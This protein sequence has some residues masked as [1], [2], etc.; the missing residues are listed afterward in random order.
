[1]SE[2]LTSDARTLEARPEGPTRL[3]RW[4]PAVIAVALLA[5]AVV[6]FREAGS[7]R[8]PWLTNFV[9]VFVSLLVQAFPFVLLGALVSAGIEVFVPAIALRR[10]DRL[11]RFLQLPVAALSGLA[12]P[13]C[14]CGS[15]PVARRL[16]AK[17]LRPSAA[18]AFML[19]SPVINPIVIVSTAVA[20][21]GRDHMLL[22]VLGR[23]GLGLVA[24]VA[25][26]W[27]FGTRSRQQLLR[28][29]PAEYQEHD[30]HAS[31]ASFFEHFAA[32]AL[33]MGRFLVVG[34][35]LAG[36][37]QT[38]A[39]PSFVTSVAG[40]PVIDIL[41]MMALA[42]LLSLCSE[43]DAFVAASFI[44]FSPAAQLAFLVF[45]PLFNLKL[46]ALYA[47]T[48]SRGFVRTV[49]VLAVA[50]VLVGALWVEA[51]VR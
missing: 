35:A 18:V 17:G 19:A 3:P 36:V 41:A 49:F 38:F 6:A 28:K 2:L 26:G 11:P 31:Q 37:V 39:P 50:V 24:A 10:L 14:E 21:R 20:Y 1:M 22:I 47:G 5:V 48:F 40:T 34:A 8:I 4:A 51:F 13:L 7:G 46:A 44:Q 15:V 43:S 25:V 12:F 42:G 29:M 45:G 9:L 33:F 32:D 30:G 23:F 16:A 27:V